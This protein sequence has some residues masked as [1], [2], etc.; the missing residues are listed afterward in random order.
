MTCNSTLINTLSVNFHPFGTSIITAF[1]MILFGIFC[2]KIF[3]RTYLIYCFQSPWIS[4]QLESS[5]AIFHDFFSL[6]ISYT[7]YLL[8]GTIPNRSSII[9]L[10]SF[11][12][13]SLIFTITAVVLIPA[14]ILYVKARSL[15]LS[16]L[17]NGVIC[18]LPLMIYVFKKSTLYTPFFTWLFCIGLDPLTSPL[19]LLHLLSV[20]P[21]DNRPPRT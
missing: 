6:F 10:F 12:T 3:F 19:F 11:P 1:V 18:S 15:V 16:L 13:T 21:W 5:L 17:C 20:W 8:N 2:R 7:L 9:F 14:P 4:S